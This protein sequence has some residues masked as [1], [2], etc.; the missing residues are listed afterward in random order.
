MK[1]LMSILCCVLLAALTL[2]L[3]A[4]DGNGGKDNNAAKKYYYS[5]IIAASVN[6]AAEDAAKD[7]VKESFGISDLENETEV[8]AAIKAN[9]GF[10]SRY[11]S[12]WFLFTD[13]NDTITYYF[14]TV[15]N[16]YAL[17]KNTANN[18]Y[19]ARSSEWLNEED[20]RY[21]YT[22]SEDGKTMTV[23]RYIED[24][25]GGFWIVTFEYKQK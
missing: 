2:S 24:M 14:D 6:P 17:Q 20:V 23:N 18:G 4:C 15:E 25:G 16:D 22:I 10:I 11:S 21:A 7:S 1:K 19:I 12:T 9:T 13:S 5:D 8:I 3:V